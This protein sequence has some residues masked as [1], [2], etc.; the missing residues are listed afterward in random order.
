M[1]EVF[2]KK[3]RDLPKRPLSVAEERLALGPRQG[4]VR[5]ELVEKEKRREKKHERPKRKPQPRLP[6]RFADHLGETE[7]KRP[8]GRPAGDED[9]PLIAPVLAGFGE[10]LRRFFGGADF[11]ARG[12]HGVGYSR[13]TKRATSCYPRDMFASKRPPV[14]LTVAGTD[15]GGCAGIAAD[16]HAIRSQG[17]FPALAVAAVTA[18][19]TRGVTA[20]H[21][22]PP[23]ILAAQIASVAADLRPRAAKTGMLFDAA[24]IRTASGALTKAGFGGGGRPLVVDPVMVAQSGARLLSRGAARALVRELL[25]IAT[26]VTPNLPEAEV[27][28]GRKIRGVKEMEDAA[29]EILSL[30]PKAVLVKGGHA[31]GETVV[32]LLATPEATRRYLAPRIPTRHTHGTGCALSALLAARLALGEDLFTAVRKARRAL[33]D[34]LAR[35]LAVGRGPGPGDYALHKRPPPLRSSP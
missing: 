14:V 9:L 6:H 24:R 8:E 19:N 5:A 21:P 29:R 27:L 11:G 33:R 10:H 7:E 4:A 3:R 26:V 35:P 17:A 12:R 15:S 30:G 13:K 16:L 1:G 31:Q 25:P 32:D 23:K 22:V 2:R 18:Q 34:A 20:V 28:T